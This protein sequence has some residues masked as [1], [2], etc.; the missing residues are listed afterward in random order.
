MKLMVDTAPPLSA[1]GIVFTLGGVIL[2]AAALLRRP[3]PAAGVPVADARPTRAQTTRAA[4]AGMVML[5]GGQGL[6]TVALTR[7]TASL[8]AVLAATI[9]LWIVVLQRLRG[10]AVGRGSVVR[11]V[12]GFAG[13]GVVLL[14]A[15]SAA[16]GG[17]PWAVVAA[18]VA[19]LLWAVGTLLTADGDAM[20][21]DPVTA[22][23]V[24]LL[25]G[26]GALLVLAA[27]AGQLDPGAW[28][29]V[30]AQSLGAGAALLVLDSLAGFTLYTRLLRSAP[31]P[32]VA[33][34][35]Y[36]TPLVAVLIGAVAFG[37]PVWAGALFGAALV[38]GTVAFELSRR[39]G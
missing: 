37:E 15:P 14:T 2:L 25:A 13:I 39:P 1:A 32:L 29:H 26:G 8:T 22:G 30:S 21:R 19:P 34:Y 4:L 27:V 20:P 10:D 31:A 11:L 9:P 18:C 17:S 36:V 16:I 28:A 7:L 3:G 5:V 6:A 33:T 23:A 38:L 24:Q 35:S 12:V